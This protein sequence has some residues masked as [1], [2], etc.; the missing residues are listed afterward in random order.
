MRGPD[1][2]ALVSTPAGAAADGCS[3]LNFGLPSVC[4]HVS[5]GLL[6][7]EGENSRMATW[8]AVSS[9][10]VMSSAI[11]MLFGLAERTANKSRKNHYLTADIS[12]VHPEGHVPVSGGATEAD[13][14]G[15]P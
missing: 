5:R 12:V 8:L 10:S 3:R 13:E 4:R 7:Q 6:N 9:G 11:V 1:Q 15:S 2:P 14:L